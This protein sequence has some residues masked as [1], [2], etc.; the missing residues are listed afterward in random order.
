MTPPKEEE[1]P[2]ALKLLLAELSTRHLSFSTV[3]KTVAATPVCCLHTTPGLLSP[4]TNHQCLFSTLDSPSLLTRSSPHRETRDGEKDPS[5]NCV[6]GKGP[7][8]WVQLLQGHTHPGATHPQTGFQRAYDH[9]DCSVD[10]YPLPTP[11]ANNMKRYEKKIKQEGCKK[12]MVRA[13]KSIVQI[14]NQ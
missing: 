7:T 1:A 14:L 2:L 10:T 8:G 5:R 13:G 6:F 3:E 4:D 12:E 9:I 11:R